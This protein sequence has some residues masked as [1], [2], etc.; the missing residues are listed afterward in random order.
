[1]SLPKPFLFLHVIQLGTKVIF[2]H[3]HLYWL[4]VNDVAYW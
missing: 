2:F 4:A 1:M 3:D